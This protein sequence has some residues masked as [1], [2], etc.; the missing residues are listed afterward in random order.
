METWRE[1][2][3]TSGA[4]PRTSRGAGPVVA[5]D[6]RVFW[7]RKPGDRWHLGFSADVQLHLCNDS[8]WPAFLGSLWNEVVAAAEQLPVG[9][10]SPAPEEI[11]VVCY[12]KVGK[13]RSVAVADLLMH[14]CGALTTWNIVASHLEQPKWY[15][16][17]CNW[18]SECRFPNDEKRRVLEARTRGVAEARDRER[19]EERSWRDGG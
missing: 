3:A 16:S 7:D 4:A 2:L 13:H 18:C 5:R 10:E 12:C 1:I 14:A 6:C 8:N 17:S 15:L 11:A 9:G 19:G